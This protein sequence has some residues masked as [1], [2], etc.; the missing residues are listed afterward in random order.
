MAKKEI[1]KIEKSNGIFIINGVTY[2]VKPFNLG[3]QLKLA[4]LLSSAMKDLKFSLNEFGKDSK[5]ES[6]QLPILSMSGYFTDV[7]AEMLSIVLVKG[8]GNGV[9]LDEVEDFE[10]IETPLEIID[11]VIAST[12]LSELLKKS[13]T[14]LN[15][16]M[17]S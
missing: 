1:E 8:N 5:G 16:T 2:K 6:T 11:Y 7:M 15:A 13:T 3:V 17:S 10:D 9:T 4:R 14:L 12:N